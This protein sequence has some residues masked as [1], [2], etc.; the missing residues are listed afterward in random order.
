MSIYSL[1]VQSAFES[2][3]RAYE[4]LQ[5]T[6]EWELGLTLQRTES[7]LENTESV[8]TLTP[9]APDDNAYE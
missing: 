7:E 2:V 6:L 4:R 3:T 5:A 9:G 8:I 1:I